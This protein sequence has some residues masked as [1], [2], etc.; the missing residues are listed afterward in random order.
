V[1]IKFEQLPGYIRHMMAKSVGYVALVE[2]ENDESYLVTMKSGSQNRWRWE[3]QTNYPDGS[4]RP[5][6]EAH[7]SWC[8]YQV[9]VGGM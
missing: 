1:R 3:H 8:C 2:K 5:T 9:R 4:M 7:K 6:P